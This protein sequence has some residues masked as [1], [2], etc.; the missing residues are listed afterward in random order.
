MGNEV[1]SQI[2]RTVRAFGHAC[3]TVELPVRSL[4]ED[5]AEVNEYVK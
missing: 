4:V 3:Q 2:N 1:P 5:D